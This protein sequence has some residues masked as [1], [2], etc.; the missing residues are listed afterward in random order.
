VR[1]YSRSKYCRALERRKSHLKCKIKREFG[2]IG[3]KPG[4]LMRPPPPVIVL[5]VKSEVVYNY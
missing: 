4:Y 2:E 3:S 1:Y 5:A